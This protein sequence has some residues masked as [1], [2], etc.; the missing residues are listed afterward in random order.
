MHK[1]SNF[2]LLVEK[3]P[4][5]HRATADLQENANHLCCCKYSRDGSRR[6]VSADNS[7][8]T[9]AHGTKGFVDSDSKRFAF[10]LLCILVY[11]DQF[12]ASNLNS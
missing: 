6:T 5:K 2:P 1:K 11:L 9:T 8:V 4:R 7:L 10:P 12:W 3:R